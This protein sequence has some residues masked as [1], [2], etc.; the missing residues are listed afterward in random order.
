MGQPTP[1]ADGWPVEILATL[2]AVADTLVEGDAERRAKLAAAAL[3]LAAD[4]AQVTQ[5]RLVLRAFESRIANLALTGRPMRFTDLDLDGREAYLRS[6]ARSAIP[7][8]RTAYQALKRLL[9]FLAWADPGLDGRN[10]RLAAIG[11]DHRYEPVTSEPTPI[12]PLSPVAAHDR[13]LELE[14]DVA[15]VGSGAGGGVIAARLAAAGRSVV[16]LEAGSFVPEPEMPR[17]ELS[18]FDR[19]YLNHG[20]NV[21]WDASIMTM[22]GAGV[23]G[24]TVVN[25]MTCIPLPPAARLEW[26]TRHGI[27]GF[28]GSGVDDDLA[29]LEFELDISPVVDPAPKDAFLARGCAALGIEVAET[30]RNTAGCGGCSGCTFGC[31]RGAKRSG[32]RAHLSD[33]WRDGAR[34][35]ADAPVQRVI[36]DGGRA[37]GVEARVVIDGMERSLVVRA[38]Q[39]VV[40]AGALRS[41]VVL[42][43]S[44]ID[45]PAMGSNLRLHP[46]GVVAAFL[47]EEVRMW[48][49]PLQGVRSLEGCATWLAGASDASFAHGLDAADDG[50][51][52]VESAPGTPGL[53]A[54]VMPWES[55]A[56]FDAT[57]RRAARIAP[58][59]GI[60]RDQGSGRVRVARSGRPRIDY[61]VANEDR[62]T[63]RR[64]MVASA[65]IAWAG[66]ARE[67][68]AVGTPPAWLRADTGSP[69]EHEAAFDAF[70]ERL[71]TFDF[72]PNRGT[73]VSAHQMGS[74]RAGAAAS[75]PCDPWGRVRRPEARGGADRTIRG[76]YVGDA[77]LFPTAIGVNPMITTMLWA[78]R[79]ARTVLAEG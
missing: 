9:A 58:L 73:V 33:A 4:P 13:S 2:A 27:D 26:A 11:Y 34:I 39:V 3:D 46:V 45:H 78:S 51:F 43:R 71:A 38:A 57:M 37:V 5:L 19:L 63:L 18:A 14:A 59:I 53:M 7:Q 50:S 65:R 79:V 35:V 76:L 60:V 29:R 75:H 74:V 54:L 67:L 41:P 49:G 25:W 66:G 32:L 10:R 31:R 42:L 48:N 6:W 47:D 68:V 17:D 23:G 61:L 22:A 15:I 8:R 28:D 1:N 21:S 12:R 24:G 20:F 40:A 52:V 69:R 30:R 44:G 56:A 55:R 64:A 16:V 72:G 70:L 36:L 77:S 62:A